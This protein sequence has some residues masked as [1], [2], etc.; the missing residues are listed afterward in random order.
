[1]RMSGKVKCP[2]N[3]VLPE[4]PRHF[5]P[6]LS[7]SRQLVKPA[8]Q[9]MNPAVQLMNPAVQLVKPTVQLARQHAPPFP[10]L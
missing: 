8:V 2:K 9:L 10:C 1:M 5:P 6:L 7:V 4:P 3:K